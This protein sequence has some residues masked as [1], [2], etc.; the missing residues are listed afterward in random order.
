MADTITID[1]HEP[2]EQCGAAGDTRL[3]VT[4]PQVVAV[5][6]RRC[7]DERFA[8]LRAE[9]ERRLLADWGTLG[10]PVRAQAT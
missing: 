10:R 2:C 4:P 1:P 5:L 8:A 9:H 3:Y 6:C 7:C